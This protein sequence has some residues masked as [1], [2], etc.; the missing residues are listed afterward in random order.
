M[1]L[2]GV[3]LACLIASVPASGCEG[4]GCEGPT[5][6]FF[7]DVDLTNA[8]L[9]TMGISAED[10]EHLDC[11]YLCGDV[12]RKDR[13]W[14]VEE[15]RYCDHDLDPPTFDTAD[16]LEDAV[17]GHLTCTGEGMDCSG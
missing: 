10:A 2:R 7:I 17:V 5:E 11:E 13:G 9:A 1:Q 12:Y 3:V 4:H 6:T 15:T 16:A 14:H 8:D